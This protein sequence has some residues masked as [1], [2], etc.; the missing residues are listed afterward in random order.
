MGFQPCDFKTLVQP[1]RPL[2]SRRFAPI[3]RAHH[4][5]VERT[6]SSEWAIPV[7]TQETIKAQSA[8][9]EWVSE[10]SFTSE[11][12]QQSLASALGRARKQP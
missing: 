6:T 3:S 7:L 1:N 5:M 11:N 10:A 8:Q 2:P 12:F 9:I 4:S